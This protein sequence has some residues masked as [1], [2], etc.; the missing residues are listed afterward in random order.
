MLVMPELATEP[1]STTDIKTIYT[2][3]LNDLGA[4]TKYMEN[5]TDIEKR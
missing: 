5:N 4:I 2:V 1:N 3:K